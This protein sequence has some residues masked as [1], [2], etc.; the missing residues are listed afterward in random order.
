MDQAIGRPRIA[1]AYA[2]LISLAALTV[3]VQGFLF[4]AFYSEAEKGFLD[5][6]GVVAD[7]SLLVVALI[8]TPLAFLARFP[9]SMRIGWLTLALAVLWFGQ[10]T[11]GYEIEDTRWIEQI[12]IPLGLIIF[13]LALYLTAKAHRQISGRQG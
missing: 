8:I 13:G 6:H 12:H 5:A 9:K 1:T 10:H 7:I 3:V 11:I 4:S 2:W